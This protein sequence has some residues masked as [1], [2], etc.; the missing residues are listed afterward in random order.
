MTVARH[1]SVPE[2]RRLDLEKKVRRAMAEA[3][4]RRET[5]G[6]PPDYIAAVVD[7]EHVVG[8]LR[9]P[10][11]SGVA[12]G[13]PTERAAVVGAM[14]RRKQVPQVLDRPYAPPRRARSEPARVG[15]LR[16]ARRM[17]TWAWALAWFGGGTFWDV[18]RRV[19]SEERRAL[20]LRRT[21]ERVGG[22]F[23]KI[24]QQMASRLDLLPLRY[25]EELANMFD[26]YPPFP[27]EQAISII[28]RVTGR[29][30]EE[31]FSEFDPVPIGS[32]SVACVYQ[33]R[34][35]TTGE[36][37]AVKVRR[38]KIRELFEA[39]FGVLDAICWLAEALSLV[40]PGFTENLRTEF[41][42]SLT[43]ELDFKREG[44][45]SELF[46]RRA[47]KTG[48][49]WFTAPRIHEEFSHEEMLVQAFVSGIWLSEVLDALETRNEAGLARMRDLGVDP[50]TL[51]RRLLYANYWSMFTHL[52]F[53]A[54]PHP[55]N[56]V[57]R[58]NNTIVF[59]DFGASGFIS[60]TRRA[61]F[62]RLFKSY[63]EEDPSG[64]ARTALMFSEPLPPLDVNAV[65][66]DI[67]GLYYEQMIAMKS[68]SSEWYER[69]SASIFAA[70]IDIMSRYKVPAPR[71]ILMYARAG[72]LYDTLAARLDRNVNYFNEYKRFSQRSAKE[73]QRQIRKAIRRRLQGGL[74]GTDYET[75][76]TVAS[77]AQDLVFRAQ[78]ILSAPYD[79]AVVPFVI[80]K[81]VFVS[82]TLLRFVT[83]AVLL[84]AAGIG[85]TAA[86]QAW[87]GAAI[88]LRATTGAV[89]TSF[90]YLLL[91]TVAGLIHLR[92]ITYRLGDKIRES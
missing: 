58:A 10:P 57:V 26:R 29:K 44:R 90:P 68:K 72:L 40:R 51:A 13:A 46:R 89:L 21:F 49:P 60:P 91:V 59:I 27:T 75:I 53:H 48:E 79:F 24:G 39:D 62:R 61:V 71:D 11:G 8:R 82:M 69:T 19:D 15:L 35:R 42:V 31:I 28:E 18:V 17:L 70:T 84:A 37:V 4:R 87:S 30:L 34:L 6:A 88:D 64:M 83:I 74:Q 12:A 52:S 36:R 86:R 76:R 20:R 41:R 23:I 7:G 81:G 14:P 33:A 45:L 3:R 50:P 78:R 54:D 80:E 1:G 16:I 22:T 67:E 32:A 38:P 9:M 55:A 65:T 85:F 2:I 56:I 63:L 47:A 92:R 5:A 77:T 66:R 73:S 25:C 43:S